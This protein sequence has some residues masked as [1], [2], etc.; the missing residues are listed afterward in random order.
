VVPVVLSFFEALSS[1]LPLWMLLPLIG[2]PVAA[3]ASAV[4]LD[5]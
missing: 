5:A 2:L 3:K 1:L 4:L